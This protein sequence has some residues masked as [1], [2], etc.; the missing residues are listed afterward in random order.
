MAIPGEGGAGLPLAEVCRKHGI[1]KATNYQWK[2]A[3]A[4]MSA[5]EFKRV[6]DLEAENSC[7]KKMYAELALVNAAIKE[8]LSRKMWRR[9][10]S[11]QRWN[12]WWRITTSPEAK[13][14]GFWVSRGRR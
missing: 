4:G 9:Q 7:L 2:R 6:K 3:Y 1:S 13:L 5:N 12:V 14:D 11:A 8:V 10:P